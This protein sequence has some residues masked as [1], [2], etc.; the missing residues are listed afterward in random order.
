VNPVEEIIGGFLTY[1][2][3]EAKQKGLA[4]IGMKIFGASHYIH[5]KLGITPELLIRFALSY[6]ITV[7]IVGCSTVG[8]VRTLS[9][10]GRNSK[11]L[12]EEEKLRLVQEFK[13]HARRLA[14]YRGVL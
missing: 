6:G 2:L 9:D 11:P 12:S 1:T 14:F 13:P 3:R 10:V 8:E 7:A 4:V 5:P